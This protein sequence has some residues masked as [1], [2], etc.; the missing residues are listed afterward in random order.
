MQQ[1]TLKNTNKKYGES[2]SECA[3][4]NAESTI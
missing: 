2:S 3:I 4:G 1:V